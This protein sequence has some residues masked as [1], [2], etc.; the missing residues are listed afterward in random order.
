MIQKDTIFATKVAQK[1]Y[2]EP[3]DYITSRKTN[4]EKHL[5]TRKHE[6]ATKGYKMIQ[7]DTKN[8][9]KVA[10]EF[11]C[12]CGRKYN[13]HSGLWRHKQKCNLQLVPYNED[14]LIT[15]NNSNMISEEV[16][17]ELIKDNKELKQII[18]EQNKTIVGLAKNTAVTNNNTVNQN[19]SHN[20]TFNLQLFLNE[21]CKDAINIK[22]FVNS[23]QLELSDLEETGHLGFVEGISK[24]VINN[25]DN[26]ETEQRPIHCSDV[27][28][29]ILYIKDNDEWIKEDASRE[30]IKYVIK[31]IANKNIR[32]IPEWTKANPDFN[33]YNSKT[34]DKYLKIVSNSMSGSTIEEQDSNINKIISKV[35]KQVSINKH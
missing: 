15:T 24:V 18:I 4:Y 29:E 23:I 31:Q 13:Y 3:C 35:A 33:D 20:K 21:Q 25:L 11:K 12:E 7:N 28:R 9:T 1:F 32:Q 22:D 2:C 6:F 26:L 19:N 16:V 8:A 27:K 14:Q 17:M 10:Q 30:K 34:N 5:S